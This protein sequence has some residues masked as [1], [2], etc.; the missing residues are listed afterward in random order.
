MTGIFF[1]YNI[2]VYN[3][4]SIKTIKTMIK[5]QILKYIGKGFL[6]F[7]SQFSTMTFIKNDN[8]YSNDIWVNYYNGKQNYSMIVRRS[9]VTI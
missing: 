2:Y 3:C 5:G 6:G 1:V 9:E 7:N 8:K 4:I